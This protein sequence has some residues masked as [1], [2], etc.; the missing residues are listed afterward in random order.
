MRLWP[1]KRARMASEARS[2]GDADSDT[3]LTTRELV[4]Q[5]LLTCTD[6]RTQIERQGAEMTTIRLEWSDTLDRIQRWASRQGARHRRDIEAAL[7]EQPPAP[8]PAA[9]PGETK[10]ELRRRVFSATNHTGGAS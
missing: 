3:P 7:M 9:N 10:A 8:P 1:W 6:L 2:Q 5:L 4:G